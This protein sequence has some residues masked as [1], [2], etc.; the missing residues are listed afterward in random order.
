M[1]ISNGSS[2]MKGDSLE[3]CNSAK[4]RWK[5][6][7]GSAADS[8]YLEWQYDE[9]VW[10]LLVVGMEAGL[11]RLDVDEEMIRAPKIYREQ[12]EAERKDFRHGSY[13]IFRS[14]DSP[15]ETIRRNHKYR[16]EIRY[17]VLSGN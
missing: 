4:Q 15:A 11:E 3:T 12:I 1:Y 17:G 8:G 16:G 9:T 6:R 14:D 10:T 5:A 7:Y 13:L 2:Y